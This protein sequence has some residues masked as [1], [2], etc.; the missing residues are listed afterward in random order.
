MPLAG[1]F[2]RKFIWRGDEVYFNFGKHRREPLREVCVTD[3]SYI[4][5]F[6]QSDFRAELNARWL[7][8][9]GNVLSCQRRILR[10][11]RL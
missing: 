11:D 6:L 8:R 4:E 10:F 5:W 9:D 1:W 7:G 2:P 3:P